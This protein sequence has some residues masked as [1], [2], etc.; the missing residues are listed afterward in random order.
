[1]G[2]TVTSPLPNR[3]LDLAANSPEHRRGITNG[4]PEIASSKMA[5]AAIGL[6][7]AYSLRSN[8]RRA[9]TRGQASIS[10][11]DDRNIITDRSSDPLALHSVNE[12]GSYMLTIVAA[13]L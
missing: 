13:T 3:T 4:A 9:D 11:C 12:N 5:R 2:V 7:T 6:P 1:M 8:T 10:A